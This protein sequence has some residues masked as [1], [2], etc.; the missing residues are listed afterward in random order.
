MLRLAHRGLYLTGT[1]FLSCFTMTDYVASDMFAPCGFT[2]VATYPD[3]RQKG[4]AVLDSKRHAID[5][6][7]GCESIHAPILERTVYT[8]RQNYPTSA[9]TC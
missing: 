6:A 9:Y 5:Y 1:L 7:K 4:I 8:V 3:G 2:V